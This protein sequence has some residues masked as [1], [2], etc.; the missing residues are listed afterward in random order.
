MQLDEYKAPV[1][2]LCVRERL[3]SKHYCS[4][5]ARSSWYFECVCT[6]LPC[7][8]QTIILTALNCNCEEMGRWEC[9]TKKK[10]G[11]LDKTGEEAQWH[12][13]MITVTHSWS[14]LSV[15]IQIRGS[16]CKSK[17]P[18]WN[19]ENIILY[20]YIYIYGEIIFYNEIRSKLIN[21]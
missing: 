17:Y 5:E 9:R 3:R 15:I 20:I 6:Q 12:W 19:T 7:T 8:D 11:K 16:T 18:S 14:R 2:A 10:K 21:K 4:T 13:D 1:S